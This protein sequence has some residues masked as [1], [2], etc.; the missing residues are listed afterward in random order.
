MIFLFSYDR[1]L[2]I[3]FSL[4]NIRTFVFLKKGYPYNSPLMTLDFKAVRIL[5][6]SRVFRAK[7]IKENIQECPVFRIVSF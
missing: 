6:K 7:P 1:G 5:V 3:F 2:M 4:F